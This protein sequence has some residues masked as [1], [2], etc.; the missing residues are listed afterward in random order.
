MFKKILVPVDISHLERVDSMVSAARQMGADAEII[1]M[2]AV[3]TIPAYVQAEIPVTVIDETIE[4]SR[5]HLEK[6]AE[7]MPGK[8][9]VEMAEG[10]AASA[11]L[12][13]ADEQKVDAI[14]IASHKPGWQDYLIG[15]TAARVVRHAKCCVLVVR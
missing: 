2:N 8:I 14:V 9:T 3:E 1:L 15:S 5:A 6:L 13:L 11:I 12:D 10:H 7:K 4:N